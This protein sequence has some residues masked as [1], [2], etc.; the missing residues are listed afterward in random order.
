M[1][2]QGESCIS[3]TQLYRQIRKMETPARKRCCRHPALEIACP[4]WVSLAIITSQIL[5]EAQDRGT[6]Y[7]TMLAHG[8]LHR[9]FSQD[10]GGGTCMGCHPWPQHWHFSPSILAMGFHLDLVCRMSV[11]PTPALSG[12]ENATPLSWSQ[13]LFP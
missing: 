13:E 9:S 4:A 1:K 3:C 8:G 6:S 12:S 5:A 7:A 10:S 2:K 11:L